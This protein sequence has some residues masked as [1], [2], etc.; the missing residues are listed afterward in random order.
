MSDKEHPDQLAQG[1][2]FWRNKKGWAVMEIRYDADPDKRSPE[3]LQATVDSMPDY[4]S[5]AREFLIDWTST[6]GLPFYPVFYKR[7]AEERS[8]FIREQK[9]PPGAQVFRGFDFGFRKPACVWAYQSSDGVMRILREF[10]PENI[11]VY[12]FRDAVLVLSGELA[13]DSPRMKNRT[14]ALQ[15][16]ERVN[17]EPPWF[18]AGTS[19]VNFCGVE[20]R[21]VQSIT[22][23]HGEI[24]DMEV[25]GGGGIELNIVNQRV[26]AGTYIIRQLMKDRDGHPCLMVDPSCVNLIGGL[27]GGLTFGDG[28]KATPLD[29]EVAPSPVHSH[30][31]DALRYL[32]TGVVNVADI[33]RITNKGLQPKD[34]QV[35]SRNPEP[36]RY[37]PYGP[38]EE[39]D[40]IPFWATAEE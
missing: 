20:A 23:D 39:M 31:H 2:R 10:T 12:E 36:P 21:H 40:E 4:Q 33:S 19:F 32:V 3:W 35:Y 17:P 1:V 25:M 9:A 29:D 22:G 28:T 30:T 16:L 38:D 6:T 11:D 34:K 26:S 37:G 13:I 8:Y 18:P 15:W 5:F 27:A 24:N 14:R 7:Y